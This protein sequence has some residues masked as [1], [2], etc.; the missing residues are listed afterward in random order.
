VKVFRVVISEAKKLLIKK[1]STWIS[2]L[3]VEFVNF[4]STNINNNIS[5][6]V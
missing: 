2:A 5:Y 6:A 1:I 4:V 3:Y